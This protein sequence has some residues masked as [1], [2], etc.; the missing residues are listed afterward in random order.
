MG[1]HVFAV[2]DF[3]SLLKRLQKDLTCT[4]IPW[5]PPRNSLGARLINEIALQ[6]ETDL[7][8]DGKTFASHFEI[9]KTAMTQLGADT[10]PVEHFLEQIRGTENSFPT[11]VLENIEAPARDFML[12]N[13]RTALYGSTVQVLASFVLAREEIIPAMFQ[14]LLDA[15]PDLGE[16]SPSLNYYLKRHISVDSK[17]HGPL[18]WQITAQLLAEETARKH[19]FAKSAIDALHERIKLWDGLLE[20]LR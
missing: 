14:C 11:T 9:Y 2:W 20:V 3:M 10:S 15:N 8:E 16:L 18:A 17:I 12:H 7:N 19:E 5:L 6:E 13:L 4:T 1:V